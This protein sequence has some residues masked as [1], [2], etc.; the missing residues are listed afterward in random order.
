MRVETF[1]LQNAVGGLEFGAL[2]HFVCA[3]NAI[4]RTQLH[5]QPTHTHTHTQLVAST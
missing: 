3:R 1:A 5:S 2:R 4:R